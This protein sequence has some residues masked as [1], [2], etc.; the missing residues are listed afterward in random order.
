MMNSVPNSRDMETHGVS[1]LR[2]LPCA[3]VHEAEETP[4]AEVNHGTENP[5]YS[6]AV[7]YFANYQNNEE[8]IFWTSQT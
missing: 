3:L 6:C 8:K 7:T 4:G 1:L 5:Y 2:A